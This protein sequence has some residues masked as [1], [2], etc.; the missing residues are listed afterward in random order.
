MAFGRPV[1][2]AAGGG[3]LELVSDDETG[4]LV[5]PRDAAA[6]RAAVD[7]LLADPELRARLGSAAR[8]RA[9]DRFGWDA[10]IERTLDVYRTAI[11]SAR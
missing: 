2:A 7:R 10:V 4:L 1:V 3:L 9:R 6:L 11:G 8:A 5:P